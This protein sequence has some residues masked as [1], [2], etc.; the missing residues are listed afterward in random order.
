MSEIPGI[1]GGDGSVENKMSE[2]QAEMQS[3]TVE[4]M[5]ESVKTKIEGEC[6]KLKIIGAQI[7]ISMDTNED[8][9]ILIN[10]LKIY[11]SKSDGQK[12]DELYENIKNN[13]GLRPGITIAEEAPER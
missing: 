9:C 13:L 2:L 11:I 1:S 3:K 7:S 6:E 4:R 10:D 5:E 12:K 8:N